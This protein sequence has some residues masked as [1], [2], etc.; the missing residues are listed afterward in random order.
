MRTSTRSIFL[1]AV[2]L[3]LALPALG[4]VLDRIVAVVDD[5]FL[6]TLSDIRKER[7]IQAALGS[8]P[9]DD[10]AIVDALIERHL[11]EDQIAQFLEIE[12]PENAVN[13]R[14]RQIGNQPGVSPQDLR[15]TLVGE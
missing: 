1:S 13:E 7:A 9:G 12:V 5:K 15:E 4:E 14:L 6:V 2:L 3:L 10:D 8:N 11:V